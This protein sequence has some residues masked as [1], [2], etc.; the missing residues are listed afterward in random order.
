MITEY[1]EPKTA[2]MIADNDFLIKRLNGVSE[3]KYEDMRS[4]SSL[5]NDIEKSK[6]NLKVEHEV[7][8]FKGRQNYIRLNFIRGKQILRYEISPTGEFTHA[9]CFE[10]K[11]GERSL[12]ELGSP[13]MDSILGLIYSEFPVAVDFEIYLKESV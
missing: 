4:K 3:K 11:K 9:M 13:Y 8:V 5:F 2:I 10:M 6:E 7:K 1:I 12:I